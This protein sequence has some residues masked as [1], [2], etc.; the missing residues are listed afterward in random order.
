MYALM[1]WSDRFLIKKGDSRVNNEVLIIYSYASLD[2]TTSNNGGHIYHTG[3]SYVKSTNKKGGF[4][5]IP[6]HTNS[7]ILPIYITGTGRY[8][9]VSYTIFLIK[10]M[11]LIR[12]FQIIY[13]FGQFR[14]NSGAE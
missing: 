9:R 7:H 10:I 1:I 14:G 4:R 5:Y 13:I 2:V 6:H 11:G 8:T 12:S 3:R